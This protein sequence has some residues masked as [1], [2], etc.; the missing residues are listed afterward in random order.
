MHFKNQKNA[1]SNNDEI[2]KLIDEVEKIVKILGLDLNE[3]T[4]VQTESNET[5]KSVNIQ[6]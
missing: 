5:K 4:S 2:K 3:L 1:I 6:E